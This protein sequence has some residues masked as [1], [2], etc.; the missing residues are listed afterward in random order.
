MLCVSADG[1]VMRVDFVGSG[2]RAPVVGSSCLRAGSSDSVLGV[3]ADG[4]WLC[5]VVGG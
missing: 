4:S 3:A 5:S 2:L 1:W